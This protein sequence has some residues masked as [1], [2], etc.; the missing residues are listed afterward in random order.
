MQGL[1]PFV[2]I[3]VDLEAGLESPLV[4]E[5]VVD[6]EHK[7]QRS[8]VSYQDLEGVQCAPELVVVSTVVV[9]LAKV[10]I[11]WKA[12]LQLGVGCMAKALSQLLEVQ[13]DQIVELETL[14]G[15][16]SC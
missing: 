1:L 4:V 14:L 13:G 5:I 12:A 3:L 2:G 7:D 9:R 8:V 16:S 10:R 15:E 6:V 11:C